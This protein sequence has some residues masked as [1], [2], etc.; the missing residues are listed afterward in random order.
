MPWSASGVEVFDGRLLAIDEFHHVSADGDNVLGSQLRELIARDK[1]HNRGNDRFLLP[2]R[3]RAGTDAEDEEKFVPVTY[4]YYEQLNGYEHLK[5]LDI[6]Y[7]FYSGAYA[8]DI[9]KVLDPNEKHD[10]P[11]P[12]RQLPREHGR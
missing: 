7:Y 1:T 8:D 12:Q 4:T 3:R 9:L 2:G 11:H 6:G 5:S 10:H